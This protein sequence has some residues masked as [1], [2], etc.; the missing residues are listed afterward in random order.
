LLSHRLKLFNSCFNINTIIE[1]FFIFYR[2]QS[3]SAVMEE[4][5]AQAM[6]F[7]RKSPSDGDSVKTDTSAIV[8]PT[9]Q[10]D[11]FGKSG[12]PVHIRM[13]WI[14]AEF[15]PRKRGGDDASLDFYTVSMVS[16]RAAGAE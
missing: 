3:P 12:N 14:P 7:C 11:P 6:F 8:I 10:S 1:L 2:Q 9:S 4:A 16:A 15:T 5:N 13:A